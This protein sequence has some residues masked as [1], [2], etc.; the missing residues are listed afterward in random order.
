MFT[1][2]YEWPSI[3]A[4]NKEKIERI[5]RIAAAVDK[6]ALTDS[7]AVVVPVETRIDYKSELNDRQFLAAVTV[8][9]PVL[10]IAGAGSGKT[11]TATYRAS[12]LIESG[13]RP[14]N[15][16]MLSFTRKA[17]DEM[18]ER[19]SKLISRDNAK[20]VESSTFHSFAHKIVGQSVVV[21]Q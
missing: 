4:A 6:K 12:Y 19:L 15:I 14:E 21:K 2:K 20:R 3:T 7:A 9:G 13:V 5:K 1:Y 18:T 16:L 11:R 17:A 10:V 8:E